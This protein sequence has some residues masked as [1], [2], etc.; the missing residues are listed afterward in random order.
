[1]AVPTPLGKPRTQKNN[2]ID[3]S[4]LSHVLFIDPH[5]KTGIVEPNVTMEAMVKQKFPQF[6]P[7]AVPEFPATTIEER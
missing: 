3:T 5:T 7:P 6:L 1:M 4:D 2:A